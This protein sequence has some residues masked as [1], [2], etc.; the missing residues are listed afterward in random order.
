MSTSGYGI[1]SIYRTNG[2]QIRVV[3]ARGFT[4]DETF[5]LSEKDESINRLISHER[6]SEF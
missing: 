4:E 6:K 2:K 5:F 3:M 1:F